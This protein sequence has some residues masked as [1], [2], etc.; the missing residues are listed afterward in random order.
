MEERI[1]E[2]LK[3]TNKALSVEEIASALNLS[4]RDIKELNKVLKKMENTLAVARTKKDNYMLFDNHNLAVGVFSANPK[5]FG[6]VQVPGSEDIYIER[7]S[8]RGAEACASR[9][10]SSLSG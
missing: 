4:V 5:G 2:L 7:R 9:L 1:I 6:F 10:Q 3:K 8:V